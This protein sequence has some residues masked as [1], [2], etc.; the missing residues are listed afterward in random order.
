M[1]YP[2]SVPNVG[3]VNG[4]FVDENTATGV[5]GSLIPSAWGNAVTDELLA[6]IA[7]AQ[8]A[9]AE[10][11]NGQLLEA[12]KGLTGG[13][14]I[15]VKVFTAPGTYTPTPGTKA[16]RVRLI[17]AG[18]AG[19]GAVA[20][21]ASQ[22]AVGTGGCNGSYAEGFYTAVPASAAVSPGLGGIPSAG[23]S[24][25]NGGASSFGSL[26]SATGGTGGAQFGPTTPPLTANVNPVATSITGA[27]IVG[28]LS[29][30]PPPLFL[31]SLTVGFS[32]QGANSQLGAGG[33][34]TNISANGNN[35]TGYGAGGGG[36]LALASSVVRTGGQGSPGIVIVEE[37]S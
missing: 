22:I 24:G 27:N 36:A 23:N 32:G 35:A 15:A 2:K 37:F 5:V 17:G 34:S 9:P 4:K 12:I 19:G 21:N 11:N 25:G 20:T 10:N 6:V 28:V 18:A 29:A 16:I 31:T 3:L 13:R 30:P 7:A 1:D 8:L 26:L 33:A 14:L